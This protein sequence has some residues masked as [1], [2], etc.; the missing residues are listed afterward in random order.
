MYHLLNGIARV[1]VSC[2]RRLGDVAAVSDHV[3]EVL[4]SFTY[5]K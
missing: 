4:V 1:S 3:K 2:N 5:W